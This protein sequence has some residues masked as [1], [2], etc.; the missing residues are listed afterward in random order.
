MISSIETSNS[1]LSAYDFEIC[2][3]PGE[4]NLVPDALS[5][6]PLES[7]DNAVEDCYMVHLVCQAQSEGVSMEEVQSCLEADPLLP[8]V[9]H[10]VGQG[11]P[12]KAQVSEKLRPYYHVRQ[13]LEHTD[14]ILL[15]DGQIVLHQHSHT[16]FCAWLTLATRGWSK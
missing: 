8:T 14:R 12:H 11:W 16:E 2:Y 6:L 5:R 15:Q 10:F 7:T 9:C 4:E 1:T 13:E 3:R